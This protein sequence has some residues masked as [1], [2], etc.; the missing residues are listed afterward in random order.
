MLEK[1]HDLKWNRRQFGFFKILSLREGWSFQTRKTEATC[2]SGGSSWRGCR[3]RTSHASWRKSRRGSSPGTAATPRSS[4]LGLI[5]GDP[6]GYL[7]NQVVT[8]TRTRP[9]WVSNMTWPAWLDLRT[10][11]PGGLRAPGLLPPRPTCAH[12]APPAGHWVSFLLCP[13]LGAH[14]PWAPVNN[15]C[16]HHFTPHRPSF[17]VGSEPTTHSHA[18]SNGKAFLLG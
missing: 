3:G 11:G 1:Y 18:P 16:P 15:Q 5:V 9:C 4:S 13:P 10:R 6:E 7:V 14:I 12:P 17:P 8:S 2:E